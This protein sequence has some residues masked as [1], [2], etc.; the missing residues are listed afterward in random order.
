MFPELGGLLPH[1]HLHCAEG[2]GAVSTSHLLQGSPGVHPHSP[3]VHPELG[4][5]DDLTAVI[6]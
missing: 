2:Q 6:L 1:Q 5:Q 4:G 3:Q